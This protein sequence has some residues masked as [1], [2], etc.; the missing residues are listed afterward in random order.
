MA[1]TPFRPIIRSQADLEDAWRHLM[2]PLGFGRRSLWLMLVCDDDRPLPQLTEIADLPPRPTSGHQR[3]FGHFLGHL[4]AMIP[5]GRFAFLLTRP[6]SGG[7]D[8]VDRQWAATLYD[9]AREA[10]VPC[11]VVHVATDDTVAPIPM[12]E[13]DADQRIGA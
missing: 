2:R 12:D 4:A 13:L 6:G 11:E 5:D 8:H 10:G 3:E 9:V 1:K 7:P